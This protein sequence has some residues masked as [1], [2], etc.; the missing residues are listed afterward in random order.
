MNILDGKIDIVQ[1]DKSMVCKDA[2]QS[3][4]FQ[5]YKNTL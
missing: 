2:P 1:F 3:P 4:N 5:N